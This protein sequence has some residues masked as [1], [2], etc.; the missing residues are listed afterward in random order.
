[1]GQLRGLGIFSGVG[2]LWTL[3]GWAIQGA[4]G[5]GPEGRP[6][7]LNQFLA[8]MHSISHG[9]GQL[10]VKAIQAI[11]PQAGSVLD[12]LIDPIGVLALLTILLAIYGFARRIIWIVV[13]V[14]W[15][16]IIVRIVLAILKVS[17][18]AA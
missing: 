4:Q 16:L 15:A 1:V 6:E 12:Q 5:T 14:G 9:L 10:V 2:L 13:I 17:G 8:F 7:L 18:A 3:S 11:L